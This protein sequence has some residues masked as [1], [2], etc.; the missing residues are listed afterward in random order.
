ML[1]ML[2]GTANPVCA[3]IVF[4]QCFGSM[5][6]SARIAEADLNGGLAQQSAVA[7]GRIRWRTVMS[8]SEMDVVSGREGLDAAVFQD[9]LGQA[10][11]SL[12]RN[13]GRAP[14]ERLVRDQMNDL[15]RTGLLAAPLP[16]VTG[17]LGWGTEPPSSAA[18]CSGL[19]MIGRASLALGRV[20]EGH[21]NAIRLLERFGSVG[22]FRQ[23]VEDVRR[24]HLI[25]LWVTAFT[26]PVRLERA[27]AEW[28]LSGTLDVCSGAGLASRAVVM[29]KDSRGLEHLVYVGAESFAPLPERRVSMM[30]MRAALT[31]AVH[32]SGQVAAEAVFAGP[33]DYMAEPDFSGGAWRTSAVTVGGLEALVSEAMRQLRARGREQDPRQQARLGQ[34]LLAR[35]TALLWITQAADQAEAANADPASTVAVVNM[36]RLAIESCCLKVIP[37]VQRSLGMACMQVGNPAEQLMRDIATYLRQPAGDEVMTVATSFYL[38]CER[39]REGI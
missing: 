29:A 34:M 33:G 37:L 31:A 28:L 1:S 13:D 7:V 6:L 4:K 36:A 35:E 27:G 18:F 2:N 26:D 12:R 9:S 39:R 10:L 25:G 5:L 21:V 38:D 17:G 15:V 24:G 19:R 30:G 8:V 20:F 32:V 14:E 11:E 3:P 23:V 16:V 22:L